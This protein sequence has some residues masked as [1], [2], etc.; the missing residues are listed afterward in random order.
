LLQF[1]DGH[2]VRTPEDWKERQAEI[3]SLLIQYFIGS[4]PL[5]TPQIAGAEIVSGQ[6]HEDG[7]RRRR[8][9]VTLTTP[10]RASFEMAVWTPQASGSFPLLLTAPRFYQ[11][12]WAEDALA[13]GYAVCLYPGVDS[14]HREEDY[15]GYE[16]VWETFR[17][18]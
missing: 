12:F 14:H 18:E 11:R 3:R 5:E 2:N 7:S 15:P 13:R 9:R 17:R 6:V 10:D 1:L 16:R 8:I 4:F